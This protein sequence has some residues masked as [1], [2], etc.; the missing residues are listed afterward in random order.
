MFVGNIKFFGKISYFLSLPQ[1]FRAGIE[2]AGKIEHPQD[3]KFQPFTTQKSDAFRCLSSRECASTIWVRAMDH[4][5]E[6]CS[7][8]GVLRSSATEARASYS[9]YLRGLT[10]GIANASRICAL[11]CSQCR[12]PKSHPWDSPPTSGLLQIRPALFRFSRPPRAPYR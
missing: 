5:R 12:R 3:R 6:A 11:Y 2:I 9:D 1:E 8:S 7:R 10:I 4:R